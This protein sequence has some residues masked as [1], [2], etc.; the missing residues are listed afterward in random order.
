MYFSLPC[1]SRVSCE[2]LLGFILIPFSPAAP[3]SLSA[4][5]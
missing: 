2:R 4:L 1:C 5:S 3:A